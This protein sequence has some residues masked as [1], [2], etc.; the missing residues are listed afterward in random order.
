MIKQENK[1][2]IW[3]TLQKYSLQKRIIN[4]CQ[5]HGVKYDEK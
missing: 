4:E 2:T 5:N 1:I 3:Q